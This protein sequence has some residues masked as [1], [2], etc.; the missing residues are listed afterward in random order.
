[1]LAASVSVSSYELCLWRL[2]DLVLLVS[3]TLQALTLF[4]PEPQGQDFAGD[5]LLRAECSS[6]SQSLSNVWLSLPPFRQLQETSLRMAEPDTGAAGKSRY[7]YT[8]FFFLKQLYLVL[9]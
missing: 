9:P 1:M 8:F 7:C 5:V 2:R 6:I 3:S 4:L